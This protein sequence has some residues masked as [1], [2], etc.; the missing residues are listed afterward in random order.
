MSDT[1]LFLSSTMPNEHERIRDI[2]CHI[3]QLIS[4]LR[5]IEPNN[6][7]LEKFQPFNITINSS[8]TIIKNETCV[9][10]H[11]CPY[12]TRK[13]AILHSTTYHEYRKIHKRKNFLL[14]SPK[15]NIFAN[16]ACATST[17]KN[18]P[19]QNTLLKPHLTSTPRRNKRQSTNAIPLKRLLYNNNKLSNRQRHATKRSINP[20]YSQLNAIDENPQWI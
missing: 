15:K 2:K 3:N 12:L 4:E 17:P 8:S 20:R 16:S 5:I 7:Y 10:D 11:Q 14:L 6:S 19:N 1:L 18:S 9:L 13:Q